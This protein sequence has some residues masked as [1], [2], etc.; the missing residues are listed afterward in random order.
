MALISDKKKA[1]AKAAMLICAFLFVFIAACGGKNDNSRPGI[2]IYAAASTMDLLTEAA[3]LFTESSGIDVGFEFASSGSLARK[4]ETGSPTDIFI[5]ANQRWIDYA[6]QKQLVDSDA[7][8]IFARNSLVCVE[9]LGTET[10]I[11]SAGQLTAVERLSIGDPEHVPAGQYAKQVLEHYGL[12]DRLGGEGKII[13]AINVSVA[14]NY[15]EQGDVSVGIVYATDAARSSR[16]RT[17]FTFDLK[18]HQ[19][20]T[21]HAGLVRA[22]TR[23]Q[24][25]GEF[26]QFLSSEQ[27]LA[28]LEKNGFKRP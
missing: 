11:T 1:A 8:L 10:G 18:S 9:P 14:L 3:V 12:W 15:V 7:S 4:I 25:A 23:K 19:P 22:G 24:E 6:A 21:Y 13:L 16:V 20:I 27:F 28:L 17:V 2:V 5:S 26:M